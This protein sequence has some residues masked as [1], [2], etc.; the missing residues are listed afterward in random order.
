MFGVRTA[1]GKDSTA[2]AI[3]VSGIVKVLPH[4]KKRLQNF[5]SDYPT[6]TEVI[7]NQFHA[8]RA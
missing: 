3:V 7:D 1:I 5:Q 6:G 4:W 2:P 8:E